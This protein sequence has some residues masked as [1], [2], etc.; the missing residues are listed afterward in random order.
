MADALLSFD[1]FPDVHLLVGVSADSSRTSTTKRK[2]PKS[3][4]AKFPSSGAA[5]L[6]PGACLL[7]RTQSVVP[8]DF[9]QE[10]RIGRSS[11]RRS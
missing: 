4:E 6:L 11:R 7:E 1:I 2:L 3:A 9:P 10:A 5:N 8:P